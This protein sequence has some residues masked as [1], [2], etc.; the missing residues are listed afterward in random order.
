MLASQN[1]AKWGIAEETVRYL[2]AE[3][4]LSPAQPRPAPARTT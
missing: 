3:P 1:G 2:S 4:A